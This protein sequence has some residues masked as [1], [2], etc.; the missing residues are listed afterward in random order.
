[1]ISASWRERKGAF[2]RHVVIKRRKEK[3][4]TRCWRLRFR[5]DDKRGEGEI[6]RTA[7]SRRNEESGPRHGLYRGK[8]VMLKTRPVG[9]GGGKAGFIQCG[10]EESRHGRRRRGENSFKAKRSRLAEGGKEE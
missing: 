10:G 2:L 3:R 5:N 1:M 7:S 6:S 9:G 4:G 8:G